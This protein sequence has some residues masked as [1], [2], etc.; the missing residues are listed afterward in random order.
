L[1]VTTEQ[2]A[3][4]FRQVWRHTVKVF[5]FTESIYGALDIVLAVTIRLPAYRTQLYRF[6]LAYCGNTASEISWSVESRKLNVNACQQSVMVEQLCSLCSH[7]V[8]LLHPL[9]LHSWFNGAGG[10]SSDRWTE[11][12]SS[13]DPAFSHSG[14]VCCSLSAGVVVKWLS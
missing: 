2:S 4:F 12:L 5:S 3:Q 7:R 8:G 9:T 11:P 14:D 10:Q 1:P 13:G 6:C